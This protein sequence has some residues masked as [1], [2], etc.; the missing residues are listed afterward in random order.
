MGPSPM[1]D[2]QVQIS[3]RQ[4]GAPLDLIVA[5]AMILANSTWGNW[6]AELGVPGIYR[7]QASMAPGVKVRMGTKALPHAGIGVKSYAW[8][9]SP[10]RRYTDMVNQWQI[11]ACARHGKTAALAA[12]F[13]PKDAE[14]FSIISGFDAAYS[15]YNGYQAGMER[16]WTLKY[17]QQQGITELDG[18]RVQGR[19]GGSFMVRAD[20]LPLVFPVLGAQGLPR[21]AR[22]RVKLGAIDEISAG[23]ERHPAGAAGRPARQR[24]AGEDEGEDE[25]VAGPIAIA[26]DLNE[27]EAASADNP[28]S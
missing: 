15:A 20:T 22:L 2:E 7:S 5:E 25:P 17:L 28:P 24:H 16:F 1:G 12:P 19:P 6:L 9:T 18:H 21:G 14:L 13:K 27:P 10:L 4:R 26:V 23:C 3:V 11:I 8:S